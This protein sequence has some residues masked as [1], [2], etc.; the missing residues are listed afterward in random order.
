MLEPTAVGETL[1]TSTRQRQ[2][3]ANLHPVKNA[4]G[5]AT[6]PAPF[7]SL[8]A[9]LGKSTC[10]G[11]SKRLLLALSEFCQTQ[12]KDTLLVCS[13]F[14]KIETLVIGIVL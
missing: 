5:G 13:H 10:A 3:C 6:S 1:C 4:S 12:V 9:E 11:T 14:G 8:A 7:Q 2:F